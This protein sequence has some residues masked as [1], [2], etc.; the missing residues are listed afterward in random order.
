MLRL[1]LVLALLPPQD[2][3]LR[4]LVRRLGDDDA[5]A[6]DCAGR[7]LEKRG[8]ASIDALREA[9]KDQDLELRS[10]A[11]LLLQRIDPSYFL[12]SR[13]AAQRERKLRLIAG[14]D[15]V[16]GNTVYTDGADFTFER[17]RWVEAGSKDASVIRIYNHSHL[18]G[19]LAWS[20][21]SVRTSRD[22]PFETCST[23]SPGV[24]L[25]P[26]ANPEP[27]TVRI[28]GVRR[29]LC[30]IPLRFNAPREGDCQRIGKFTVTLEWPH[31]VLRCDDPLP[32]TVVTKMLQSWDLL[33][34]VAG[35]RNPAPEIAI[36]TDEPIIFFPEARE[37]LE[38]VT[39]AWCGCKDRPARQDLP[40]ATSQ[41]RLVRI[42]GVAGLA[43]LI[44]LSLM[45]HIPVQEP[46][47][48]TSPLLEY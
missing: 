14:P 23:H 26:G 5:A 40:P 46:F 15:P 35:L 28:R 22:L 30:D 24:I 2:D 41:K 47:D 29:W 9:L 11:S 4:A 34:T 27:C 8:T 44:E 7:E 48:V 12:A 43:E 10:R 21:A 3:D 13:I 31:V 18:H 6:R 25:L 17:R 1:L 33:G 39:L 16:E 19:E 32:P 36:P 20:V 37:T 45:L 42:E 38:P